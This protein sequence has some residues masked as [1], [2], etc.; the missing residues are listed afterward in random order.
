MKI[1]SFLK[2]AGAILSPVLIF[3]AVY[4]MLFFIFYFYASIYYGNSV[5]DTQFLDMNI[6][7]F[8]DRHIFW[9]FFAALIVFLPIFSYMWK[10]TRK[11][12]LLPTDKSNSLRIG[13]TLLVCFFNILRLFLIAS[14]F[15][16]LGLFY[17]PATY[18]SEVGF[19]DSN[20]LF[21]HILARVIM[22]SIVEEL[23]F[24]G[25]VLNRL[26]VVAPK[27]LA[28]LISSILFGLIHTGPLQMIYATLGG[29]FYALIYIRFRNLLL[30][31]IAHMV[32]NL[33]GGSLTV[34]VFLFSMATRFPVLSITLPII[35]MLG[36]GALLVL[37]CP[38]AT[39][40]EKQLDDVT[41]KPIS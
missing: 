11:S 6:E 21:M 41:P 24:R 9:V 38:P 36:I 19:F 18:E 25:V 40:E 28:V 23:M 7:A 12:I 10:K 22:V 17:G 34:L 35:A 30:C 31:I 8:V 1:I 39:F 27:W 14:S 37:K 32:F 26:L 3:Y 33:A 13:T 5:A 20:S 16:V 15:M 2:S 4:E 29:V